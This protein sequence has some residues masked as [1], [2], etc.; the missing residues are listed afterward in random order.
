MICAF[1][2]P[3][4]EEFFTCLIELFKSFCSVKININ[5]KKIM[6]LEKQ[7]SN[8]IGFSIN[9]EEEYEEDGEDS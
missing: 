3:Y 8:V 7:H 5:N 2:F 1:L 6:S 4:L 9:S